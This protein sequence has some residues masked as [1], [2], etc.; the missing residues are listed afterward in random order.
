MKHGRSSPEDSTGGGVL[1]GRRTELH[2][3]CHP[4]HPATL[5][6]HPSLVA[7]PVTTNTDNSVTAPNSRQNTDL[8]KNIA[9]WRQV[10]STT[11]S[12]R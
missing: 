2:C 1:T 12:H 7:T 6:S 10:I 9:V 8:F 3:L 4:R 11:Y 5:R